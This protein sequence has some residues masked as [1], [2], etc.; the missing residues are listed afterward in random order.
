[1]KLVATMKLDINYMVLLS[2][3]YC[4]GAVRALMTYQLLYNHN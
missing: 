2:V 3:Y 4:V 1:M